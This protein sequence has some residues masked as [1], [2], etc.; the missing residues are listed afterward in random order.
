MK[1]MKLTPMSNEVFTYVKERM[2]ENFY[3][4]AL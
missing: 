1:E 4:R 3:R 2:V